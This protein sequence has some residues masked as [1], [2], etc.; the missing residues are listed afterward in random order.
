MQQS[1]CYSISLLGHRKKIIWLPCSKRRNLRYG[2]CKYSTQWVPC[3]L[4]VI[5][6]QNF[7]MISSVCA[8]ISEIFLKVYGMHLFSFEIEFL[9]YLFSLRLQ[10]RLIAVISSQKVNPIPANLFQHIPIEIYML[11]SNEIKS[12]LGFHYGEI[13]QYFEFSLP[14]VLSFW[15]ACDLIRLVHGLRMLANSKQES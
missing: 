2:D 1:M 9:Q 4:V 10:I 11:C 8:H 6:L 13:K 3:Y 7:T 5:D 14:R 15:L 12:Y